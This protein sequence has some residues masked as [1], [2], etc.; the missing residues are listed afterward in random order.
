MRQGLVAVSY[1]LKRFAPLKKAL[2]GRQWH[3]ER[4]AEA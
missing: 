4:Q 2:A 3:M 1:E